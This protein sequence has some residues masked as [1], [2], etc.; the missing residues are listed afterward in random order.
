MTR[1]AL[2]LL[3]FALLLLG[4]PK[5]TVVPDPTIPHQVAEG[6]DVTVWCGTTDRKL[7]KCEVR[8]DRGWWVASP[9]VVEAP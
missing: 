8:L 1:R 3:A 2:P 5:R 6:S 7:A 4:C 9:Q